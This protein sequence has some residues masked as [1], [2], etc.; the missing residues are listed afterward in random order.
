MLPAPRPNQ[1]IRAPYL[2]QEHDQLRRARIVPTAPL[3]AT[4]TPGGTTLGI[5]LPRMVVAA[6]TTQV[7]PATYAGTTITAFGTGTAALHVATDTTAAPDAAKAVDVKQIGTAAIPVGTTVL[8][9]P[10]YGEALGLF[11]LGKVC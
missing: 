5:R 11:V 1:P 7:G 4:E 3:F 8:L 9:Y 6:V 10:L 2:K